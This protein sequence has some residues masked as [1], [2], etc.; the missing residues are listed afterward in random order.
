MNRFLAYTMLAIILGTV[1]M[2]APL[3]LL[4]TDESNPVKFPTTLESTDQNRTF[5]SQSMAGENLTISD[6]LTGT[7]SVAPCET[8]PFESS[9]QYTLTFKTAE[10]SA[11]LSPIG[12]MVVPSFLVALGVFVLLRKRMS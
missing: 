7:E 6:N 11:D 12:L 1:T 2:L 10:D 4:G 3:A 8:E 9:S 5:D